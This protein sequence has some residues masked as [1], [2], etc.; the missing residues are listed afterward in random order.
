MHN[1]Q[2]ICVETGLKLLGCVNFEGSSCEDGRFER[3]WSTSLV[4]LRAVS[5]KGT[6]FSQVAKFEIE[7]WSNI[8]SR[9]NF[10]SSYA[11]SRNEVIDVVIKKDDF[12]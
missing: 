12:T 6:G 11:L 3:N 9:V 4:I 8:A 1:N 2:V 5:R 7:E 10:G